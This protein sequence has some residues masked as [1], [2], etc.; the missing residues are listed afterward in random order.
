M[1]DIVRAVFEHATETQPNECCGFV[2]VRDG[3]KSYVRCTNVASDPKGR[4]VI[5][6]E[7]YAMVEDVAE[8]L[9]IAHSHVYIPP[10][11]SEADKVGCEHSGL[12]WLIVNY[13]TGANTITHPSGYRA[14][15]IGREFCKGTLDCYS[16]VQDYLD[17]E[18]GIKLPD[19]VRPEEWFEHGRS[20]LLENFKEFGFK[21]ITLAELQPYDCIL[22]QVG[23]KVPNH[24]AV[25]IGGNLILHHVLNRL[26]SRDVY[27]EFWRRSTTH[28]LRHV[29]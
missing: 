10:A 21:E 11:P 4:F 1:D 9:M 14:P 23:S 16:L 12:P 5:S 20:I 26:S 3:V 29:G 13:P 24:C 27:G 2:V 7:E 25:Y 6:P 8:I 28:Y 18:K 22:M 15:I 19:Y 17:E